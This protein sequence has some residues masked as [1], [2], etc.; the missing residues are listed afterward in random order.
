[1]VIERHPS[2]VIVA[3]LVAGDFHETAAAVDK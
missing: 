1:L 2:P 3:D